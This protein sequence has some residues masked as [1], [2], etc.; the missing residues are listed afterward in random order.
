M[1]VIG[2]TV[3]VI[4]KGWLYAAI[5]EACSLIIILGFEWI[6][7]RYAMNAQKP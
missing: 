3:I 6:A 4:T 5:V 7:Y 1:V 2:G